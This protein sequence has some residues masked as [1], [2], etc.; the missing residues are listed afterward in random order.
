MAEGERGGHPVAAFAD[1]PAFVRGVAF[2]ALPDDVVASAQRSLLDLIGVA[3]A[4]RRTRASAIGNGYAAP[5]NLTP[6]VRKEVLDKNPKLA[7]ALNSV[8]AKLNDETMAK[9]NASVDVDKK[10]PEEVA[11]AF[12]KSNGLI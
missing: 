2:D 3:A 9:L 6:V 7:D 4:G 10:T 1:V 12:L 5:Y 11:E 8:S